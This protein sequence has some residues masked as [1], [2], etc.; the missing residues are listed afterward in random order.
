MRERKEYEGT[1]RSIIVSSTELISKTTREKDGEGHLLSELHR[2]QDR[3]GQLPPGPP[4]L[5]PDVCHV[6]GT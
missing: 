3:E 2:D 1:G 4:K 6:L 5:H